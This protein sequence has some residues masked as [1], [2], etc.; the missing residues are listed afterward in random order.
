[1]PL[2]RHSMASIQEIVAILQK[3][4]EETGEIDLG[5]ARIVKEE[6]T[7]MGMTRTYLIHKNSVKGG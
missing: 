2:G 7:E 5:D 6:L 3:K 4:W 1:M